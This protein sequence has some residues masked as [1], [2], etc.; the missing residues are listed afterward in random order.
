MTYSLNQY[1]TVCKFIPVY[2]HGTKWLSGL[3]GSEL[4]PYKLPLFSWSRFPTVVIFIC[5][6]STHIAGTGNR[7]LP[8]DHLSWNQH[9]AER[10][11]SYS[12]LWSLDHCA[13]WGPPL[14]SVCYFVSSF[15]SSHHPPWTLCWSHCCLPQPPM[16]LNPAV[17]LHSWPPLCR[18]W[19]KQ[20]HT[21]SPRETRDRDSL[22]ADGKSHV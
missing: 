18:W 12:V 8:Q 16:P 15:P 17:T 7:T 13:A 19:Q 10:W 9:V 5:V 2:R 3:W 4:Q 20:M 6:S 11:G 22:Q 21:C 14:L 1:I